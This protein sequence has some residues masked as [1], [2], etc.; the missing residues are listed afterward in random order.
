MGQKYTN[1]LFFLSLAIERPSFSVLLLNL[2]R[3]HVLDGTLT[4]TDTGILKLF[5]GKC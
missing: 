4:K 5:E 2:L 3:S 1:P